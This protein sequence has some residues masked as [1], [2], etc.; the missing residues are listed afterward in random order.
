[1]AVSPDDRRASRARR[2]AARARFAERPLERRA[3]A[4]EEHD[5]LV[6]GARPP[7]HAGRHG[8]VELDLADAGGAEAVEHV[9]HVG[10]QDQP[11]PRQERVRVPELRHG[12]PPTSRTRPPA[13]RRRP[14]VAFDDDD[15]REV[16]AE[17]ARRREPGERCHPAPPPFLAVGPLD[18]DLEPYDMPAMSPRHR[19]YLTIEQGIGS[20]VFNVL[21]NAGIAWLVFRGMTTV[22]LL[23]EQSIAGD[24]IGTTLLLPLLTSVIAGRIV[25]GHVRRGHVPPLAW[26][27][28][29]GRWMPRSLALRGTL[30]GVA[31]VLAVGLPTVRALGVAGVTGMSLWG[32][33]AFKAL[34]AGVLA[35]VVTPLIA[36]ASLADDVPSVVAATSPSA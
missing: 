12:R 19:T 5:V 3:T 26:S 7:R 6:V 17:Q 21:L 25:R 8:L 28:G 16:A 22:P 27:P 32:F 10:Q 9:G 14:G 30:L 23:G 11:E 1:M 15:P 35:T 33:V 2:S 24:T 4:G 29:V 36:R 31:C 20:G 13:S 34:F 18:I